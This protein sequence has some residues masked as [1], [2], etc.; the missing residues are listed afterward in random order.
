[1]KSH[2]RIYSICVILFSYITWFNIINL[3]TTLVTSNI[4]R[5]PLATKHAIMCG[6]SLD[7]SYII[8]LNVSMILT[9]HKL[10]IFIDSSWFMAYP[11][12]SNWDVIFYF[13]YLNTKV[14]VI[15]SRFNGIYYL[16]IYKKLNVHEVLV[17]KI[18]QI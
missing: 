6:N 9:F 11:Y 18:F 15:F 1:M 17:I 5:E 14:W 16:M 7:Y 8:Y 13:E 10:W 2:N 4:D 3:S 12:S